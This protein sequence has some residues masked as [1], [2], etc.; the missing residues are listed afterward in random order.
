MLGNLGLEWNADCAYMNLGYKYNL[1]KNVG[2]KKHKTQKTKKQ[3]KNADD[4]TK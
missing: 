4:L 3:T 1:T 2:G